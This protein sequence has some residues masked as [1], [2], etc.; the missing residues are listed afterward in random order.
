MPDDDTPVVVRFAALGD[1]VLLTGLL[2]GLA[3]RYGRPLDV[4]I[5][6]FWARPSLEA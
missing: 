2:D 1:T 3:R 5:S 4:L 6:G